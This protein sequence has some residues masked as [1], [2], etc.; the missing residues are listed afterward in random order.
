MSPAQPASLFIDGWRV[1]AHPLFLAQIVALAQ[2]VDALKPK[3]PSDY[4]K[5]NAGPTVFLYHAQAKL[6]VFAWVNDEK[7]KRAYQSSNDAYRVFRKLL[8]SGHPPMTGASCSM[9]LR[10][11]VSACSRS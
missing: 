6:I 5:K 2:Q 3:Y 1:F 8:D 11:R 10:L 9:R 4:T 7:T